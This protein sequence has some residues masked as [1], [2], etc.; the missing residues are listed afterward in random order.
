[1]LTAKGNRDLQ[2]RDGGAPELGSLPLKNPKH[3]K[4]AREFASGT[5]MNEAWR[6][7]GYDPEKNNNAW[8]TFQRPEIRSRVEYLRAEFN[9]MAGISLAALQ[10]R[11]LRFADANLISFFEADECGKMRMR[12]LT[13]LPRAITAPISELNIDKDGGIKLKLVDKLHALDSLA[14]TIGAFAPEN[15]PGRGMTLE[16]LVTASM[17]HHQPVAIQVVTNVPQSRD[18]GPPVEN[19]APRENQIETQTD[20]R[21]VRLDKVRIQHSA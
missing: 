10:A 21:R 16:E 12:D 17:A 19:A 2:R 11:W 13:K 3:E 20:G 1:M 7:I 8:R 6:A 18:D 15:D 5:S 14:K 4:L 9:K